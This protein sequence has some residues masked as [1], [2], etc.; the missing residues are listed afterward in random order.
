MDYTEIL[1]Q[2]IE[3]GIVKITLNQPE[4]RNAIDGRMRDEIR[5]AF[6]TADL[7]TNVRVVILAAAG[8]DFG[9]GYDLSGKGEPSFAR[10][11]LAVNVNRAK[12]EPSLEADLRDTDVSCIQH[13]LYIRDM[14]KAT[15]AQVQGNCIA[16]HVMYASVCDIIVASEDARFQDPVGRWGRS[17][18]EF[19]WPLTVNPRIAKE[20]VWTGDGLTAQRAKESGLVSYVVSREKLE[21]TALDLARRIARNLP[22]GIQLWKRSVNYYIDLQG[23]RNQVMYHLMS[24]EFSHGTDETK[25]WTVSL[26]KVAQAGDV[27][28]MIK[29]RDETFKKDAK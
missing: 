29:F 28:R 26:R 12:G 10:D 22:I 13:G 7:D 4:K 24:H 6:L 23:Q 25:N 15:I 17:G 3:P 21:D 20:A 5:D 14:S 1:Y 18:F 27:D 16:A 19:F 8:K 9:A 2:T 11:S